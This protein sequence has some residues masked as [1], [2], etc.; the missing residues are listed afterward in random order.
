MVKSLISNDFLLQLDDLCYEVSRY[1]RFSPLIP[2]HD[3]W[4]MVSDCTTL[5]ADKEKTWCFL[6][7]VWLD[8]ALFMSCADLDK[9][10]LDFRRSIS[11][12]LF[13]D[14]VKEGEEGDV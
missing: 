5:M 11:L 1:R 9:N 13:K 3:F 8:Q 10:L 4:D 2:F 7:F 14:F 6:K 12:F